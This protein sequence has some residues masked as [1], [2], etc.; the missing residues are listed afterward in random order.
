MKVQPL[1]KYKNR[2]RKNRIF[3]NI[4]CNIMIVCMLVTVFSVA[5][6]RE[7]ETA[8][9]G[10]SSAIYRGN[11]ENNNI[12]LM[13][14]VYW[15]EE[16]IPEI[17]EVLEENNVQ[18]TFFIGGSWADKNVATLNM[19]ADAG[20]EI[21]NHGYWHKDGDKLSEEG[22][23]KE[24]SNAESMIYA[25]TGIKTTLFAPPS[26]AYDSETLKA[27]ESLGYQTI[28]WSKDT[29]DWRDQDASLIY[30]R[31]TTNQQNGDLILMHPTAATLEALD[32]I[33]KTTKANGFNLVSVSE[34]IAL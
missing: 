23:S 14:N 11:E 34:N 9:S 21:A 2:S 3:I 10:L 24:I 12:S 32:D 22:N 25:L 29:I 13:I 15:G 18:A 19:I 6:S 16:Y 17:L 27:A 28:M 31:A 30:K 5:F 7:I 4:F 8:F 20:H 1:G 33:I 26:G